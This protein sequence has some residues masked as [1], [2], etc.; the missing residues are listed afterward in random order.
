[1]S[2]I[3][4]INSLDAPELDPI[5]RLTGRQLVNKLHPDEGSF[6]V[7][8]PI[9]IDAALTAGCEPVALLVEERFIRGNMQGR[10]AEIVDRVGNAPVYVASRELLAGIT[11]F[12]LTRGAMCVMR[13][14]AERGWREVIA[15][16]RR[17]AV[18]EN[19]VDSTNVGAIFRS[20]AGLGIDTVLLTPECCDP[21]CR[22]AVRV[23]MGTVLMV[24]F[25]RICEEAENRPRTGDRLGFSPAR[26]G[27]R[28]GFS[29]PRTGDRLEFSG[30]GWPLPAIDEL[31]KSGFKLAAMAL[32]DDSLAVNDPALRS[33]EKLAIVLG[34][35]GDGLLQE[36]IDNCDY[37]VCIPMAG[38]VDSLNVGAAAA[39][40]FFEMV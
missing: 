18:L 22:R 1:M 11:G 32:R 2:N 38:R 9:A 34:T 6:V 33:A 16:A 20:A 12:E 8:S 27:D 19:I 14:P 40:A 29:P 24:P 31:K 28:L 23:S 37:T 21:L 39:I 15:G 4:E 5:L 25:A 7:E 17:V 36:T 26:T 10:A 3:I 13:R 35:E 30:S